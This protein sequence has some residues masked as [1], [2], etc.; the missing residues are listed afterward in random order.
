VDG[1]QESRRSGSK[2]RAGLDGDCDSPYDSA[3]LIAARPAEPTASHVGRDVLAAGA[4]RGGIE[5]IERAGG[6]SVGRVSNLATPIST[7]CGI[8]D[9]LPDDLARICRWL[10]SVQ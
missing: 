7:A 9:D 4:L 2:K 10:A 3:S 8:V 1:E 5:I 6:G